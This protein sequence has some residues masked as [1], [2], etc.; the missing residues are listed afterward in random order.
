MNRPEGKGFVVVSRGVG[1]GTLCDVQHEQ[2]PFGGMMHKN[3]PLKAITPIPLGLNADSIAKD[4]RKRTAIYR[5]ERSELFSCITMR[6]GSGVSSSELLR[7]LA[8]KSA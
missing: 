7:R 3:V 8:R 6:N 1:G 2:K 4:R 5:M